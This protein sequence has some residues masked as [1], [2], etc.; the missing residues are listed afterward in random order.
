MPFD[1]LRLEGIDT[2]GWLYER[3]RAALERLYAERRLSGTWALCPS[4][5]DQSTV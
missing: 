4:T 2:T 5:T 3:R 1:L